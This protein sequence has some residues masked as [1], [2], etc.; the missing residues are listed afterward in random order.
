MTP[1][2]IAGEQFRKRQRFA[3]RAVQQRR[4]PRAEAEAKLRLW[5]AI[6]ATAG[7]DL[8]ELIEEGS[9]LYPEG[10]YF[11][12]RMR[13]DEV[14]LDTQRIE[15]WIF[16]FARCRD[17]ALDAL[18]EAPDD[19]EKRAEAKQ[20]IHLERALSRALVIRT[21]PAWMPRHLREALDRRI[22]A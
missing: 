8:P 22:A 2:Q 7:A 11:R 14:L 16:E 20:F 19:D 3:N 15:D 9:L 13:A 10:V 18:A 6:T 17:A 4:M 21:I 5:L 1:A 12:R